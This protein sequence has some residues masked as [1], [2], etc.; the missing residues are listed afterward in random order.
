MPPF[1]LI[2]AK[3]K[4][5]LLKSIFTSEYDV[6]LRRL[7]SARKMAGMTQKELAGRLEKPQSFVSKYEC[8]E[9]RLDIL[10]F[11]TICRILHVDACSIVREMEA[12]LFGGTDSREDPVA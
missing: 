7:V 1:V 6:F 2:E 11:V 4:D 9:R 10:E 5:A 12:L 3:S 8:R